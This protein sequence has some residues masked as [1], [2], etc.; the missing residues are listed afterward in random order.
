MQADA[1]PSVLDSGNRRPACP[2]EYVLLALSFVEPLRGWSTKWT[3]AERR[4]RLSFMA[5]YGS[6]V[7]S[8]PS[9]ANSLAH[10]RH[11]LH[12]GPAHRALRVGDDRVHPSGLPASSPGPS[13]HPIAATAATPPGKWPPRTRTTHGSPRSCDTN[14]KSCRFTASRI[15]GWA[16]LATGLGTAEY[17]LSKL[18]TQQL[19]R[20]IST[21]CSTGTAS[22]MPAGCW[23]G[24]PGS[25]TS[26]MSVVKAGSLLLGTIQSRVQ[27][28]DGM[29][30]N[31]ISRRQPQGFS[32]SRMPRT[33]CWL[34][35][36]AVDGRKPPSS[37]RSEAKSNARTGSSD[38]E[39]QWRN[40]GQAMRLPPLAGDDPR[41]A[42]RSRDIGS[43]DRPEMSIGGNGHSKP[44]IHLGRG[45][46]SADKG[47]QALRMPWI[48]VE[49]EGSD[50]Q[51]RQWLLTIRLPIPTPA[52]DESWLRQER[53]YIPVALREGES[54]DQAASEYGA[55]ARRGDHCPQP[56]RLRH[57][58]GRV[59]SINSP[60]RS[61]RHEGAGRGPERRS[62]ANQSAQQANQRLDQIEGR[63]QLETARGR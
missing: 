57:L 30:A 47:R 14:W 22:P 43:T 8:P 63:V 33:A 31:R 1:S 2:G 37:F 7:L 62:R 44:P 40:V 13:R 59:A 38:E 58:Q 9:P 21:S 61:T 42:W 36:M 28:H 54:N 52:E 26:C 4:L 29:H 6:S 23:R 48:H 12:G 19:G 49:N 27:I 5:V 25:R 20:R 55:H 17:R 3:P 50:P 18:I 16:E 56:W 15:S 24:L 32:G 35:R 51:R 11:W 10:S 39:R 46:A 45:P 34:A 41:T 53:F 60:T